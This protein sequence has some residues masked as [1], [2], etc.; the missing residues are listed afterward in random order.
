MNGA[1]SIR[2]ARAHNLKNISIEIPKNRLVVFTGLSGSGKSSLL[3]DTI[4]TEAQRQLIETFS[5]YARRA[6]PKLSRPPVDGIENLSASIVIDQKPMGRNSRSTVGTATEAYAYLRMLY[7]RFGEPFI[8]PSSLFSFNHPDGMCPECRGLG[9]CI[10]IDAKRLLDTGKSLREGAILH[11]DYR[12]GGWNWREIC[13]CG[14]FDPDEPLQRYSGDL[15]EVLLYSR[16]T[17]FEKAHGAGTY[18]KLFEG[19]AGK[20]ERLYRKRGEVSL[21]KSRRESFDRFF[22][23]RECEICGGQ[24]IS[25]RAASVMVGGKSI[26]ECV[27]MELADLNDFMGS[28]DIP[29]A[30]ELIAR[31]R[32]ITG[33]LVDIGVGYLTLNRGVA[34]L[35]G[36]E[37][38]RVKMARQLDCGL[39]D[40]L[41][42]LDEPSA[43]LH[44]T[45]I[46]QLVEMLQ[47]LRDRGNSVLVVEH[48]PSIV[49][50]ADCVVDLGPGA[51]A[52][53]GD[54][55]F[56]GTP[57]ELR[58]SGTL[59]GRYLVP[60]MPERRRRRNR[61]EWFEIRNAAVNN[62]KNISV[63]IPVGVLTCVTGVA[64]SGKSTLIHRVFVPANPETIVVSQ[65]PPAA[66]SRSNP[67]TYTG[68][69]DDIRAEFA[70]AAGVKASLFS[71]NSEGACPACRG[72]GTVAV[73]MNF[74]N[75]VRI[76]CEECGG[77]RFR[78]RVLEY[79]CRGKSIHDVLSMTVDTALS[80]YGGSPIA[81]RLAMLREVGLE[82]LE[83]GQPLSTLSGGE[84]QRLKLASELHKSGNVYVM[85]EPTRGLHPAD[86]ERIM[87]IVHG[88][89]DNGNTVIIV[90]H[91]PDVVLQADWIIDLGPG[92]G[93]SGGFVV[94]EGTPDTVMACTR[95]HTGLYLRRL[96]SGEGVRFAQ[97]A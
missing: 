18:R 41:Y 31:I 63:R 45:N 47:R 72:L 93:D 34:T 6:L 3:F 49:M 78:E 87:K 88:L 14:L 86:V 60:N 82:Y 81:R 7:S 22:T 59:T 43:G 90:E 85:D 26:G 57:A 38:Q 23:E 12:I 67:A 35:S 75:S 9:T 48:D 53:G 71:F 8:G 65:E 61:G 33:G 36:G 55:L 24:R 42:I 92:G 68:V 21:S 29:H 73:E 79:R 44:P 54:V 91:N 69:F 76:R 11:P 25:R 64:G 4:Y 62:L 32:S 66:S 77:R 39:V 19:V 1:I 46:E 13:A 80:F 37:S 52:G 28:L 51:G 40:L 50:S 16:G 27:S 5:P 58:S 17:G 56:T 10:R 74:M 83:L 30:G 95:S 70:R 2:G 89:A 96:C 94:A 15:M 20:L 97:R 84:S